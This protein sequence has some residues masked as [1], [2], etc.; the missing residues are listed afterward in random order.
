MFGL[1]RDYRAAPEEVLFPVVR[2]FV[3]NLVYV[4]P[5][6]GLFLVTTIGLSYRSR[7]ARWV[8]FG[9]FTLLLIGLIIGLIE[10]SFWPAARFVYVNPITGVAIQ[11]M[12]GALTLAFA[13]HFALSRNVSA[14][15]AGESLP[16][17]ETPPPPPTFDD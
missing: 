9:L 15:F 17:S 6:I 4:S 1:L 14:Y 12:L 2:V 11:V 16:F 3:T 5:M 13:I 10:T 8:T 7:V